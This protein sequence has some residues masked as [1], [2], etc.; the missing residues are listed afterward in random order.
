MKTL[1]FLRAVWSNVIDACEMSFAYE[2]V[3]IAK[4]MKE[5]SDCFEK[6]IQQHVTDKTIEMMQEMLAYIT[7]EKLMDR[8]FKDD[9]G[10]EYK[11]E[12]ENIVRKGWIKLFKDAK[13]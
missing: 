10:N 7:N 13:K 2:P 4:N 6:L 12:L 5:L 11:K 9:S 8:L 1:P 3:T